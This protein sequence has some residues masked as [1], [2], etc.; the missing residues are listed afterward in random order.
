VWGWE[1]G[2]EGGRERERDLSPA[3]GLEVLHIVALHAAER[4][5]HQGSG[6]SLHCGEREERLWVGVGM[7][8]WVGEGVGGGCEVRVRNVAAIRR[9]SERKQGFAG[10]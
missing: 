4:A 1:G 9:K 6:R 10:G 2:R 8:M 7:G 3:V 5:N